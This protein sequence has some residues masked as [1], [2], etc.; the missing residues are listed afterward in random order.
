MTRSTTTYS[1]GDVV[2]VPFQFTDRPVAKNRPAVVI[3]SE[4]YHASRREVIV[5]AITSRLRDPLFVGDHVIEGWRECGLV[6]A[7]VA[8]GII[9]TVKAAMISR[10][11]GIM[12]EADMTAYQHALCRAL[13]L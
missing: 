5:A 1:R 2:F 3:S 7:S 4:A 8:T 11:V 13:G 10:T 9:R 6:R 12:P